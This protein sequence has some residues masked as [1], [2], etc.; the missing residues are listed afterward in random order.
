MKRYL[1]YFKNAVFNV[2]T[3][4]AQIFVKKDNKTLLIGSW[5]GR[6]FADNSRYLFQYLSSNRTQLELEHVVW[7]TRDAELYDSL[8]RLGY[9]VCMSG[10]KK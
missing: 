2:Y 4:I 9:E 7:V 1:R 5:M 6:R 10:T 3:I 8:I